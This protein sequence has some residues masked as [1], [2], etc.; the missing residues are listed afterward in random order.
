[1]AIPCEEVRA[2]ICASVK[3]VTWPVVMAPTSTVDSAEIS[4]ELRL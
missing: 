4:A 2:P 1:M 3:A